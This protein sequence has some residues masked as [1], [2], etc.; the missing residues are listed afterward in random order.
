MLTW[1]ARRLTLATLPLL[2]LLRLPSSVRADGTDHDAGLW[3]MTLAQGSWKSASPKLENYLWWLDNHARFM[4]DSDGFDVSIIRPGLGYSLMDNLSGWVGYGWIH[5]DPA[6]G[7]SFDEHR[8]W[9]QLIWSTMLEPVSLSS[10]TR[11]EQR[12]MEDESETGWRLRQ[13]VKLTYPFSFEPRLRLAVYDE[14]FF[15]LNDTDWGAESGFNQNR[16]FVGFGLKRDSQSRWRTEIGYL[17]QVINISSRAD[18]SNHILSINFY[19][20][21]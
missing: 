13:F 17:N 8:I 2:V 5:T 12:F 10:R 14:A 16:V 11:L 4:D 6:E 3:L 19:R 21:P 15:D 1:K 18:R 9:Q 20:S 7:G